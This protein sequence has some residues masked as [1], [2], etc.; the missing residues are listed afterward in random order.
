MTTL[1]PVKVVV[2]NKVKLPEGA[3]AAQV[4]TPPATVKTSSVEPTASLAGVLA[5]DA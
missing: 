2:D 1:E 3:G 4:G 5:P